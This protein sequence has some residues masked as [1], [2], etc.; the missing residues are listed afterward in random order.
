MSEAILLM[1]DREDLH[2]LRPAVVVVFYTKDINEYADE[3]CSGKRS[4]EF[5][6]TN[7]LDN[8]I[9]PCARDVMSFLEAAFQCVP[10]TVIVIAT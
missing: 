9:Q 5:A 3:K 2:K 6:V 1:H 10:G 7:I 4:C 8:G